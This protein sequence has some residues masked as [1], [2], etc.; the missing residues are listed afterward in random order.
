[1]K[2]AQRNFGEKLATMGLTGA[3]LG[4]LGGMVTSR[5]GK[6]QRGAGRGAVIGAGTEI[7]GL[8]GLVPGG[9]LGALLGYGLGGASG[10][11]LGALAGGGLGGLGGALL[12]NTAARGLVPPYEDERDE[13][14]DE[15][16]A[17]VSQQAALAAEG[18][19][20]SVS[21][22]PSHSRQLQAAATADAIMNTA[23]IP[24]ALRGLGRTIFGPGTGD[25]AGNLYHVGSLVSHLAAKPL[26]GMTKTQAARDF[27]EKLAGLVSLTPTTQNAALTGGGLGAA[28]GGLSGLIA[29]G[30]VDE[31]DE[32]GYVKRRPR[33]RLAA[34]LS[35][36]LKGGLGGAAAGGALGHFRPEMANQ[37][38]GQLQQLRQFRPNADT[39]KNLYN[40]GVIGAHNASK[41]VQDYLGKLRPYGV[42]GGQ[43]GPS[44]PPG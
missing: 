4:A 44:L 25:A 2:N 1:M 26:G 20:L 32:E 36:A 35:G 16:K 13:G 29:P 12:G 23:V 40:Q 34:M 3:G 9:A 27:G 22:L 43:V 19:P 33:S 39:F 38:M 21:A 24:A 7:G 5:K 6:R 15:K 11:G 30:E 14:E 31:T 28:L 41:S 10:A 37:A 17:A 8:A 42:P 18:G